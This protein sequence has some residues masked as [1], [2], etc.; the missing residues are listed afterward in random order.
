[1][2]GAGGELTIKKMFSPSLLPDLQHLWIFKGE[3][4]GVFAWD[5]V[6]GSCRLGQGDR[7]LPALGGEGSRGRRG[8]ASPS[9]PMGDRSVSLF[10]LPGVPWRP[11]SPEDG[12]VAKTCQVLRCL[13]M[14]EP[15]RRACP[16]SW[17]LFV[18]WKSRPL[19]IFSPPAQCSWPH[20]RMRRSRFLYFLP[21]FHQN[22]SCALGQK[23]ASNR[24]L[25][26]CSVQQHC[27]ILRSFGS[28]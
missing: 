1:M 5:G 26:G 13:L 28:W 12:A 2:K 8:S 11:G 14:N 10:A 7:G 6:L 9:C 4:W 23:P 25:F 27:A 3:V 20:Q 17:M 18:I 21:L 15:Q 24:R 22:G 19:Q 16:A